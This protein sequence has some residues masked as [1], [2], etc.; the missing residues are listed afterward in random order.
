MSRENYHVSA[1]PPTVTPP[2]IFTSEFHHQQQE[3]CHCPFLSHRRGNILIAW[4]AF[5][6]AQP[7]WS[8]GR[9]CWF[10]ERQATLILSLVSWWPQQQ[11]FLFSRRDCSLP[12]IVWPDPAE[13]KY[14]ASFNQTKQN[15][16]S[17]F[18]TTELRNKLNQS[19]E[20]KSTKLPWNERV[21]ENFLIKSIKQNDINVPRNDGALE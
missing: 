21:P 16:Q 7:S 12:D 8:W 1:S 2:P 3:Q 9:A 14:E 20:T 5:E 13:T 17:C 18:G 15:Q 11:P 4:I 19:N 10:W 6:Y